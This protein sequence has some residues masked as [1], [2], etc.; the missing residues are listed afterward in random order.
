MKKVSLWQKN[1]VELI[2]RTSTDLPADVE[3]ALKRHMRKEKK[4]S[5]AAWFLDNLLVNVQVAREKSVPI[6][7]DTGTLIFHFSVPAG[8]DTNALV[9]VTKRSVTEATRRGYLRENTLNA[10]TGV[11]F[12]T[13]VADGS[14][15]FHFTQGAR[16]TVDVRLVLKGG[17][18]ENVG[19]QYSL[20]D[21]DLDAGR[22]LAGVRRCV[23][24]AIY[25]AQGKGCAPGIVGVCIG[26]DRASGI[27]CAKNQFLRKVGD[28]SPMKNLARLERRIM[29]DAAELGIGPMG[30]GGRTTLIGVKMAALSRLPASFYV[31]VSF[32]CWAFRRRGVLLGPE[33][34]VQRWLY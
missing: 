15:V 26:G 18:S 27:E 31:S 9:A 16:K 6:C 7:Q 3:S 13:N 32:M 19:R 20:P 1:I 25:K 22:D 4:G 30:M 14:P 33:G 10:V 17:G 28:K 34:G 24:D 29:R 11:P 21:A 5:Q 12:P 23:L 8:F 2:R